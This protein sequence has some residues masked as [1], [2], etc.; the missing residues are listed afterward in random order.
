MNREIIN[1]IELGLLIYIAAFVT[2]I[3]FRQLTH[4]YKTKRR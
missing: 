4:M 1:Y 3:G 2:V